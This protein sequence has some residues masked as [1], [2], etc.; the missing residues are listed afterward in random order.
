MMVFL[1]QCLSKK[2]DYLLGQRLIGLCFAICSSGPKS[3]RGNGNG[4]F[5]A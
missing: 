5:K 4:D 3:I 2:L 1:W